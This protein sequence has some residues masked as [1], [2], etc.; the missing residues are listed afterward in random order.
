MIFN[1]P[2]FE[3]EKGAAMET[4]DRTAMLASGEPVVEEFAK[5]FEDALVSVGYRGPE[6]IGTE[7]LFALAFELFL[8]LIDG[9]LSAASRE[10][11]VERMQSP[12]WITRALFRNKIRREI[13]GGRENFR[14][15][16]GNAV[17]QA[18]LQMAKN[19]DDDELAA[20]IKYVQGNRIPDVTF[21]SL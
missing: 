1:F 12:N 18:S 19:S 16:D 13:Y 20:L 5:K 10:S 11:V 21:G 4:Y 17:Y 3:I 2:L 7:D 6:M 8:S 14:K 9:C 15:L